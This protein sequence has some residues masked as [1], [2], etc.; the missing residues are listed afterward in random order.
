M[1]KLQP[2]KRYASYHVPTVLIKNLKSTP[3]PGGIPY[4]RDGDARRK[5]RIKTLRETNL[6]VAQALFGPQRRPC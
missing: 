5:I 2:C 1:N 6:G 3:T 4:E